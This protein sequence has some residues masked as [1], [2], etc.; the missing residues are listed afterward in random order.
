MQQLRPHSHG[1]PLRVRPV[2]HGARLLSRKPGGL[3]ID[4]WGVEQGFDEQGRLHG[5]ATRNTRRPAPAVN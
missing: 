1:A 5:Q 2:Y 3:P 4:A